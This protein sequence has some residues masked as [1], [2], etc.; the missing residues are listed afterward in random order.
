MSYDIDFNIFFIPWLVNVFFN[1][2][3]LFYFLH[4]LLFF[5]NLFQFFNNSVF[6]FYSLCIYFLC[7]MQTK[8][9]FPPHF[10]R[11]A[12]TQDTRGCSPFLNPANLCTNKDFFLS[13][14]VLHWASAIFVCAAS[15]LYHFFLTLVCVKL[16]RLILLTLDS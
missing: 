13:F 16:S 11:F 8:P 1:T 3:V 4:L 9:N 7:S 12:T 15:D 6:L 14:F 2:I 5:F 10:P